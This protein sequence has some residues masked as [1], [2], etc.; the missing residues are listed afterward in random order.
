MHK[1]ITPPYFAQK[2]AKNGEFYTMNKEKRIGG[3]TLFHAFLACLTAAVLTTAACFVYASSKDSWVP[4]DSYTVVIDAG[5]GGVD[6]GVTTGDVREAELNL[7]YA[8]ALGKKLEKVNIKV[9]YTREDEGG[10]YGQP[11][12]GFKR[13]D[14]YKRKE[15]IINACADMVVS[16]HM[17]KYKDRSRSGP[18]VFYQ[19]GDV[20]SLRLA[21]NI[22]KALNAFTTNSH[23]HL[24]GDYFIL[25]C[26]KNKPCVIIEFGFLSN[27]E[28]AALLV[29]EKYMQDIVDAAFR[30]IMLYLYGQ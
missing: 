5:H 3:K 27:A 1:W 2:D 4:K 14:M 24:S 7:K 11:T 12:E 28:E 15:I 21:A 16:V 20:V 26:L 22:Q 6:G 23:S 9:V 10:L 18:Q 30:G 29:T 25:Q 19:K 17:N 8:F 13:R